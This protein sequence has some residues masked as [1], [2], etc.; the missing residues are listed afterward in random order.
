MILGHDLLDDSPFFEDL[1]RAKR[2]EIQGY[3]SGFVCSSFSRAR[4][5]SGGPPPVRD[6][7]HPLG[8]PSNDLNQRL[9]AV[10]GNLM[11]SRSVVMCQATLKGG[12]SFGRNHTATVE[13]PDD[14]GTAPFPSAFILPV[15]TD[16]EKDEGSAFVKATFNSCIYGTEYC[17]P[18]CFQGG[19][20]WA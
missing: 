8:L 10:R 12:R 11:V 9:E 14:P 15:M 19:A 20:P 1:E 3:H 4:F 17:K 2:G 6:R 18:V 13:N 16:W 5:R 7:D